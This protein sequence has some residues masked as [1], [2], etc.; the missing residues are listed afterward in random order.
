LSFATIKFINHILFWV[1][2]KKIVWLLFF[3]LLMP[4]VLAGQGQM[5][6]LAV[7]QINET[8]YAG[9]TAD[10]FLE[11]RPGSGRV[12]LETFPLTKMDTQIS[13]R[14]A[15]E[16]ACN[17]FELDCDEYDFIYTIK[18][19]SSII[20]GPSAGAA[21]SVLTTTVLE[22]LE[23]EKT[24]TV[25][26]TINSG[27]IVGPVGGL[28]SK[29]EAAAE[30]DLKVVLIPK[31]TRHQKEDNETI[32]LKEFGKEEGVLVLETTDLNDLMFYFTGQRLRSEDYEI[33]VDAEYFE[34]MK[35][36]GVMLCNRSIGLEEKLGDYDANEDFKNKTADGKKAMEKGNYY[37]AASYCFGANVQ[38]RKNLYEKNNLT[39]EELEEKA[40]EVGK[41]LTGFE[42]RVK[43]MNLTTI[44]DLQV[45]GVVI[46]RINEGKENL[47]E[48][49]ETNETYY[50]AF[51]EE[52][53]FSAQSW[54]YFF[55][56]SGKEFELSSEALEI[57]CLEKIQEARERYQY[58]NLFI[59]GSLVELDEDLSEA[60]KIHQSG[61]YKYC[62]IKASQIKAE[63]NAILSSLGFEEEKVGELVENKLKAVERSLARTISKGA[64]PILGYSYYQYAKSL[65]E[66]NK[67]VA[68]L[69]AEYAMELGNLDMYFEEMEDFEGIEVEPGFWIFLFGSVFGA[70]VVLLV[71]TLT[72]KKRR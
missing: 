40:V 48:W 16:I 70:A 57:S 13:T 72:I 26:G 22:D 3:L 18:S 44:T 54:A 24:M 30:E 9:E 14:F 55:A 39:F 31:G 49:E 32:D 35:T 64:F 7:K 56:M 52:R 19:P 47:Q 59:P 37:S 8:D 42:A 23:F 62:L 27:G 38:L 10:L 60:E 63:A 67:N 1:R 28:K 58:V 46:E 34:I 5:K 68:L 25:T 15:K 20:G 71:Y 6:L 4:V 21:I 53:L 65:S 61:D 69:Y 66:D 51:A 36:L 2:M 50:L 41:K 45:Y 29:I 33:E 11:T 43:A 17:Y 12:F